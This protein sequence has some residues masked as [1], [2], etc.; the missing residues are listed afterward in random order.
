MV[1]R[2]VAATL[3]LNSAIESNTIYLTSKWSDIKVCGV[4]NL[5]FFIK[6]YGES[7]SYKHLTLPTKA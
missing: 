2:F 6:V 4:V 3:S 1:R 5:S 7:V